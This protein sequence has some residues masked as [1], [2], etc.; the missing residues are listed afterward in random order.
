MPTPPGQAEESS[1]A[2]AGQSLSSSDSCLLSQE[3][4][5]PHL[6]TWVSGENGNVWNLEKNLECWECLF[7]W[8]ESMISEG[9]SNINSSTIP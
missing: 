5:P 1:E 3:H 6:G 8:L 2:Q 9:F 4:D 7:E